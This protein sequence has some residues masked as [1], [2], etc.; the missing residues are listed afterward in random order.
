MH[1]LK[2]RLR[3]HIPR[4]LIVAYHYLWG[5][6]GALFYRFPSRSIV[7]IGVTGTKGKTSVSYLLRDMLQDAGVK[8]A[9]SSSTHFFIGEEKQ[10]NKSRATMPGRWFLQKF[11]RN[12]VSKNCEIAIIE[13]TSEGL[14]QY[15]H[16]G[17]DIDIALFLNLHP[18]HIEHHGGF[19]KYKQAKGKMFER[20][21][22]GGTK[23][24][25]GVPV[26]KTIV[27]NLDD[28]YADYFLGFAAERKITFGLRG[29]SSDTHLVP[30]RYAFKT[31]GLSFFLEK[32]VF[33]S[34][35]LGTQGLYNILACLA[36]LRALEL[37]LTCAKDTLFHV[38]GLSGRFDIIPAKGF[39]V[40]VDY[41]HTPQSIEDLYKNVLSIFKP[42]K[43]LCVIGSAGGLR[44]KWKRPVIGKIAAQYC[45]DIVITNED[46]FDED[47]LV[48][49]RSIEQ[50]VK[51][52]LE[53]FDFKKEYEVIE[54]RYS[55]IVKVIKQAQR[56][57]VVVL[58]GKGSENT[59]ETQSG[60]VAWNEREAV[61]RALRECKKTP[62]TQKSKQSSAK[63]ATKQKKSS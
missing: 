25:K 23:Y 49:M 22:K 43:M 17:I 32:T 13:T 18:E 34:S 16:A 35:L 30:D 39:K 21:L 11:L 45:S 38:R 59:I 51:N 60:S 57:D 58:V 20:L 31:T 6:S 10:E 53:E 15:R 12:A 41:A 2:K 5:I 40:I 27:A 4:F 63:K 52:Y 62:T 1:E 48:I 36:V 42:P 55:A 19:E 26:K 7:I 44:D 8:T 3:S 50:G 33:S 24:F 29:G 14:M 54:D 47:P 28:D 37:P 61:M 46:P 9:L 56:S